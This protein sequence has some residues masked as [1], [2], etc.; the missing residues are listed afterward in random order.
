MSEIFQKI[1]DCLDGKFPKNT[2]SQFKAIVDNYNI[3]NFYKDVPKETSPIQYSFELDDFQKRAV[4]RIT[5]FKN[6]FIAAHTSS[7]KTLAAEWAIAQSLHFNKNVIYTSPIKALSNQKYRDFKDKFNTEQYLTEYNDD[8]VGIITGDVQVN[9]TAKCLV[10]TTEILRNM[11]YKA[12]PY[13]NDVDWIVFDEIHYMNDNERGRIWEEIIQMAPRHISMV[14]LSATTPNA[15][16]F[17]NWVAKIRCRNVFISQTLTRP[18]PIEHYIN[19]GTTQE[20]LSNYYEET[21]EKTKTVDLKTKV[22]TMNEDGDIITKT[23]PHLVIKLKKNINIKENIESNFTKQDKL[24]KIVDKTET[25]QIK[26]LQEAKE[27]LSN[28]LTR[29]VKNKNKSKQNIDNFSK[30]VHYKTKTEMMHNLF[31]L[32]E[33]KDKLPVIVFAFSRKGCERYCDEITHSYLPKKEQNSVTKIVDDFLKILNEKDRNLPQIN[34]VKQLLVKGI[35]IHHSGLLPILKEIVEI[36]FQNGY[37]KIL[38]ATETFAMGV[39][40]P[41]RTVIFSGLKKHDGKSFRYL[42]PGEYTQMAGRAG[43]R[44]FDDVGTVIILTFENIPDELHKIMVGKP[45]TL[46]SQFKLTYQTITNIL[47]I[48]QNN[49]ELSVNSLMRCSFGEHNCNLSLQQ[50]SY[51][52]SVLQEAKKIYGKLVKLSK[53]THKQIKTLDDFYEYMESFVPFMER[54]HETTFCNNGIK[55]EINCLVINELF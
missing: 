40:M 36:L 21:I 29:K 31:K 25:F 49:E 15:I 14:F 20:S 23:N 38:F 39:N 53:L 47:Q 19:I 18:I 35:G 24:F 17:S 46:E 2:D 7:G 22:K 45:L 34:Y 26:N 4:Y 43:R 50:I 52:K 51:S 54:I 13:L 9:K 1:Y 33:L 11:I 27:I 12:D 28:K 37:I 55:K 8:N 30:R 3:D 6:V 10:M 5:Q 32:L 42:L 44:G 48:S 16:E 41:A